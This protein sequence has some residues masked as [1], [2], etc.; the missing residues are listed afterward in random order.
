MESFKNILLP[1][2]LLG[3]QFSFK[4]FIDRRA[5]A[6]NFVISILELPLSI[7]FLALSFFSALIIAAKGQILEGLIFLLIT[8]IFSVVCV[9]LWRRSVENF[10]KENFKKAFI[11]GTL[12][13][14]LSI[15]LLFCSIIFLVK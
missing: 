15:P 9:F 1:V 3:L 14:I 4:Y 5:T 11:L 12:N 10:E 6:F 7:S 13:I 2:I 8:I